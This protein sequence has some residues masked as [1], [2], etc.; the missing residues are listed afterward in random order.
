MLQDG[1]VQPLTPANRDRAAEVI[2]QMAAKALRCLA[3]AQ[4]TD[5]LGM[6]IC[7]LDLWSGS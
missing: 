4:K 1:G 2:N 5:Q 6:H 7:F 3:F